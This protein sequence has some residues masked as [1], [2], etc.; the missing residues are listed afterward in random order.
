MK[1]IYII[2]LLITF[3]T[4]CLAQFG[5]TASIGYSQT[6]ISKFDIQYRIKKHR[7]ITTLQPNLTSKAKYPAL[8][9]SA[10]YGY[11]LGVWQPTI[12]YS[13]EGL[14]VGINRYIGSTVIGL[15]VQGNHPYIA[16][17]VT[18]FKVNGKDLFTGNDYAIIG[19]QFIS[20][21]ARGIREAIQA[22]RIGKG[23]PFWDIQT[24][25]TRKWKDGDKSQGEAFWGSSTILVFVT[26]GYHLFGTISN[27]ANVATLTISLFSKEKLNW[28]VIGKKVLISIGSNAAGFYIAYE[29][30]KF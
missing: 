8:T 18:T 11:N 7:I 4:S 21:F 24:S 10:S 14:V 23:K 27:V 25:W 17:G 1:L 13:T 12:G 19:T 6:V 30:V 26:D 9:L 22:G 28:K 5:I 29:K 15:G 20:G 16:I 2:I 3:K